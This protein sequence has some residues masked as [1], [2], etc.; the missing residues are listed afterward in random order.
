M[1]KHTPGPWKIVHHAN[2]LGEATQ[3]DG[4]NRG[5]VADVYGAT[6]GVQTANAHLIAAA[7]DMLE[8][9]EALMSDSSTLA[10]NIQIESWELATAAIKK[11]RGQ[12]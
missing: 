9:L 8:A 3:I 6:D 12:T 1:S 11:A 4:A 7:P 5:S 10:G 2:G